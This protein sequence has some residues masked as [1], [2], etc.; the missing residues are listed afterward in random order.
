[1]KFNHAVKDSTVRAAIAS[2]K[3]KI[4]DTAAD[5]VDAVTSAGQ[6]GSSFT[7]ANEID[8]RVAN[9]EY[10]TIAVKAGV[11]GTSAVAGDI[12]VSGVDANSITDIVGTP[13]GAVATADLAETDKA[14]PV[15]VYGYTGS[16]TTMF[17]RFSEPIG[18]AP[19]YNWPNLAGGINGTGLTVNSAAAVSDYPAYIR[20]GIAAVADNY[21]TNDMEIAGGLVAD[22]AG[23][24]NGQQSNIP[25]KDRFVS[26]AT[27]PY[28]N[29]AGQLE[30]VEFGFDQVNNDTALGIAAY[31]IGFLPANQNYRGVYNALDNVSGDTY[32]QRLE[33][34]ISDG[35]VKKVEM[36][37]SDD[38]VA[39]AIGTSLTKTVDG[40]A[41]ETDVQYVPFV[42]TLDT[43]DNAY[44]FSGAKTV[45]VSSGN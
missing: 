12:T 25:V 16:A 9:D 13:L 18:V 8:P 3:I 28:V 11:E 42:L 45:I 44:C 4:G 30:D 5:I 1:M 36:T 38:G 43:E 14:A 37:P 23:N 21:T 2:G 7:V 15:V 22:A 35:K 40:N 26:G 27:N 34:L 19:G 41:L 24:T 20:L 33:T 31:Y 32:E 29:V 6:S 10:V 17:V 39:T